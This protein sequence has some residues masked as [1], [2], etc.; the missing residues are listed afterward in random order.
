VEEYRHNQMHPNYTKQEIDLKFENI[1]LKFQNLEQKLTHGFE[2]MDLILKD[3]LANVQHAI[4]H[5][6]QKFK[7][8]DDK[9]NNLQWTMGVVII[10]III[11]LL[12]IA[13]N[14]NF[15]LA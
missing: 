6:D 1:D 13:F 4:V 15:K 12:A 11:S 8:V 9:V 14:T 2:K 3:G 7:H 10:P 5:L